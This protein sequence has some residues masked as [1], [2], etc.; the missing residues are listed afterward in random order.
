MDGKSRLLK[1]RFKVQNFSDMPASE[2]QFQIR[3]GATVCEMYWL[4]ADSDARRADES[5]M[6]YCRRSASEVG[7]RF[8]TLMSKTDFVKEAKGWK[9][10]NEASEQGVDIMQKLVFV[11]YLVNEAEWLDDQKRAR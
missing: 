6:E 1:M 2:G 11:A 8:K 7:D 10:M 9:V 5:W 4:S 3:L